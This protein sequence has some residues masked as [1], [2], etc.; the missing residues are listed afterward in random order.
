VRFGRKALP[1]CTPEVNRIFG[2]AASAVLVELELAAEVRANKVDQAEG[3][4]ILNMGL[5]AT[6]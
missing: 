5:L 2:S 6:A 3:W 1:V 4:R